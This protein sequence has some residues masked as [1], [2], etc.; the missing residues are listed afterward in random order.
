MPLAKMTYQSRRSR[1]K[2]T[3][4]RVSFW[5]IPLRRATLYPPELWAIHLPTLR[6][7]TAGVLCRTIRLFFQRVTYS[8]LATHQQHR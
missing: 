8:K 6:T 7:D 4:L 1:K 5:T 2:A 3:T